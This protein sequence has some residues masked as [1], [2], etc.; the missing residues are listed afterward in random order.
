MSARYRE[1]WNSAAP[2]MTSWDKAA[3]EVWTATTA[4]AAM[5]TSRRPV[6]ANQARVAQVARRK[7]PPRAE[8]AST[9][10][11]MRGAAV[12]VRWSMRSDRVRY[13][14]PM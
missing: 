14:Y 1:V 3:R 4:V 13:Q 9:M 12:R 7:M 11:S 5:A 10:R 2:L 6:A 8:V